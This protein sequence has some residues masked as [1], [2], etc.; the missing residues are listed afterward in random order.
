[1]HATDGGLQRFAAI[2]NQQRRTYAAMMAAMDDAVGA[3]RAKLR[4][5]KLE[6][7]TLVFFVNDN[8]GPTM[9]GTTINGSVNTPLRGSK[10]T[11]LEGGVRVP[12]FVAWP[13]RLP[14]GRTLDHPAIQLDLAPTALSAAGVSVKPEWNMEGVNLLPYLSGQNTGRPHE[15]L[16]WRFGQQM[17]VRQG[18]YKLV[19]YDAI[20]DGGKGGVTGPRLY[21]LAADIGE[22]TDLT[23]KEPE[24]AKELQALWDAWNSKNVPPLWGGGKQKD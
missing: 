20:A 18:D 4:E 1:M 21:N 10:R 3:V 8:G 9:V 12:F 6:E 5:L 2:P 13:G 22:A 23:A 24:K 14:A 16:Y 17:A 7:N 15:V 19:R 11:T